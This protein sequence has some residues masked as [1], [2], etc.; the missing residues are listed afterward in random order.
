M[1]PQKRGEVNGVKAEVIK[2][3]EGERISVDKIEIG[4][5]V[6]GPATIVVIREEAAAATTAQSW[7]C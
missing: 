2:L 6:I 3:K 1:A 5:T 4:Y 7:K